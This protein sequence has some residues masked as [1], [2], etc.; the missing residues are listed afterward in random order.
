MAD[1]LTPR[2]RNV[3]ATAFNTSPDTIGDDAG[4][5]QTPGWDSLGHARLMMALEEEFGISLPADAIIE[6]QSLEEVVGYLRDRVP[7]LE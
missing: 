1:Q 7:A 4:I 5:M 6:L 2:V 3:M